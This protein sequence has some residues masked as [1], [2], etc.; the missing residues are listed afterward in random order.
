MASLS[1]S[2]SSE[3]FSAPEVYRYSLVAELH[4]PAHGVW[5]YLPHLH[6]HNI[7]ALFRIAVYK[8]VHFI[9]EPSKVFLNVEGL[10]VGTDCEDFRRGE[11]MRINTALARRAS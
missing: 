4:E 2:G 5:G 10:K 8:I 9:R 11:P 6:A 3:S 1:F 7:L